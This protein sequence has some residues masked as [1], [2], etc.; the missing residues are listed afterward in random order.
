MELAGARA[1][2]WQPIDTC[3]KGD[4]DGM[5][6]LAV[7]CHPDDYL[8]HGVVIGFWGTIDAWSDD[9]GSGWLNWHEGMNE[10][11]IWATCQPTHWMPLPDAPA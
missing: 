10:K 5:F 1:V 3:P 7:E 11:D 4:Q 6:L 8:H 9:L 2:T